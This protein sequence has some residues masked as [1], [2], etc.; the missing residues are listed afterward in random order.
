MNINAD[1][2]FI[3]FSRFTVHPFRGCIRNLK[4]DSEYINLSRPRNTK[5]VQASCLA[6]EVIS[7]MPK[8]LVFNNC[9]LRFES[10][11]Y[12]ANEAP[13]NFLALIPIKKLNFL[14]ASASVLAYMNQFLV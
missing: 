6:R 8:S 2:A 9:G 3:S 10:Q 12:S 11:H 5:G 7:L 1:E 14:S 4:L 13:F